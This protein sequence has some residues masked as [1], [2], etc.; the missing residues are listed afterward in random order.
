ME[1]IIIFTAFYISLKSYDKIFLRLF[2]GNYPKNICQQDKK[3]K[4]K[5][6]NKKKKRGTYSI[7]Q[8]KETGN[9]VHA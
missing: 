2:I 3:K 4:K 8:L 9:K 1:K 7:L 6:K 5:Q